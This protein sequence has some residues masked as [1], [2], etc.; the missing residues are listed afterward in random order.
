MAI[1]RTAAKEVVAELRR[2]TLALKET[3]S[4]KTPEWVLREMG[5]SKPTEAQTKAKV[6][7]HVKDIE[8]LLDQLRQYADA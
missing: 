4:P 5:R 6:R 8:D 3:L 7:E 2:E 1:T